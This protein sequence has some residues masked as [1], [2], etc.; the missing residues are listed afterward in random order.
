M[1]YV[2]RRPDTTFRYGGDTNSGEV[3]IDFI[4]MKTVMGWMADS[5]QNIRRQQGLPDV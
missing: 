1:Q 2:L 3:F 5:F 4:Q